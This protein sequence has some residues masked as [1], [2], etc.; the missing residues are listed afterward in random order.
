[1]R[2]ALGVYK[3]QKLFA[4][5]LINSVTSKIHDLV[6]TSYNS[7]LG[8]YALK[9]KAVFARL[10]RRWAGR[11][12]P[13]R[14]VDLGVGDGGL[15]EQLSAL[16]LSWQFTGLD[17]SG[18]MLARAARR[19]AL[20]PVLAPAQ[21]A[22]AHLP[23]AAFDLVLAHFI[24]AYVPRR[25][26]FEQARQLVAP[27]GLF[28]LATSLVEGGEPLLHLMHGPL[29]RSWHPGRQL[30][31]WLARRGQ[32]RS[33]V[34]ASYAE[35]A[36]ELAATGWAV[37]HRETLRLP[38]RFASGAD[39]CQ[40][41]IEDGWGT[42]VFTIRWLPVWLIQAMLRYTATL[43][44]YPLAFCLTVEVLEL[45][46]AEQAGHHGTPHDKPATT[47]TGPLGPSVPPPLSGIRSR[48]RRG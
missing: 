28:S 3:L 21:A 9:N 42:N 4:P 17:V 6:A 39:L 46:P 5:F 31:G 44:Y 26:L 47:A 23:A 11:A 35:L 40:F 48:T 29:R 2:D 19:V 36:A 25:Q 22:A 45:E 34:P 7:S 16:P 27:G 30:L 15:L 12:A 8:P 38:V 43:L 20:T 24:L 41:V 18:D 33:H 10:R 37:N 32:S 13:L 1:M 14:V